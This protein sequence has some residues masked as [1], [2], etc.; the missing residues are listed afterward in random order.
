MAAKQI[1]EETAALLS[2]AVR[3]T[4]EIDDCR[5]RVAS[6]GSER[7]EVLAALRA[8]GVT[9]KQLSAALG[10]HHMTIQ[11]DMRRYRDENSV[12]VWQAFT[13][14]TAG[15]LKELTVDAT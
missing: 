5:N 1:T 2:E 11:Q 14:K 6:L 10:I 3:M 7:R 12:D 9:Y 8:A 4:S 13:K 15:P